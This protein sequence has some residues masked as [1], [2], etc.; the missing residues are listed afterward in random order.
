MLPT[1]ALPLTRLML[2]TSNDGRGALAWKSCPDG[3][4]VCVTP[5]WPAAM[6]QGIAAIIDLKMKRILTLATFVMRSTRRFSSG[7][8]PSF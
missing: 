5:S 4:A 6:K 7:N 2:T 8:T 3:G 1:G